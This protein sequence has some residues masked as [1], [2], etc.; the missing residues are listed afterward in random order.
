ML[1]LEVNCGEAVRFFPI[2]KDK[3]MFVPVCV[4]YNNNTVG[5]YNIYEYFVGVLSVTN[6]YNI[7]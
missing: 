2:K 6:F 3:N 4:K 1:R 7:Q 5:V